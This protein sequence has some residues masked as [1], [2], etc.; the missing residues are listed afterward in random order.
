VKSS[1][2][3]ALLAVVAFAA[4][5]V[6]RMPARWVVPPRGAQG[7]CE[8]VE[9]TLWEGTCGGLRVAGTAAG[10]LSW[11]LHPLRL[12]AGKLAAHLVLAHGVADANADLELGFGGGVIARH[13]VADVPLDPGLIPSVPRQVRGRAHLDLALLEVARGIVRQ[14]QGRIEAHDLEDRSGGGVTPL[15]S[16]VVTFPGGGGEPVGQLHDLDGPLAL[17]GTLRLTSQGGFELQGLL[18][19]RAGAPPELVNDIRFF[20]SPDA[21]G[22]RPFSLSGTF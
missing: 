17:E 22:R 14:L 21:S 2:G 9:G 5:F 11:E 20:G 7:S 10:D 18:A 12:L 15:G 6:A 1:V 19:P 8:S 13:L 16:Y 4:V 3:I